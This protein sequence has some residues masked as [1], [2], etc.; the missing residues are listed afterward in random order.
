MN[1]GALEDKHC[2]SDIE[3][4]VKKHNIKRIIETGSYKGWSTK[5]LAS[6][7]EKVDTIEI[8]DEY[9]A[10]AVAHLTEVSNVTIHKGSSP[11]VMEKI[12]SENEKN[13]LIFLD[14]HW[15]DYWPINDELKVCYKKNI[16]PIICIHDFF[17][18]GGNIIKDITDNVSINPGLG[19]KFGYDQYR[20]KALDLNF[21][22]NE[23]EMIYPNGFDYHYSNAVDEVDSGLIYIYP[24]EN[25]NF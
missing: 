8:N 10:E 20:G 7:C 13:L 19:S 2:R 21:I 25:D 3:S 23:L 18:P 24:K 5:I 17:V 11:D 4:L 9:I 16:R 14:A 12:I 22:I 1:K 15:G 6:F